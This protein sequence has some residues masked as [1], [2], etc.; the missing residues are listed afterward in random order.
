MAL[1]CSQKCQLEDWVRGHKYDCDR[2][3]ISIL[4]NSIECRKH[5]LRERG[6]ITEDMDLS[7][8]FSDTP[9]QQTQHSA[10]VAEY[11]RSNSQVDPSINGILH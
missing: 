11:L 7:I 5:I 4:L 3:Q 9:S 1:Y 6:V 2:I 8:I 10:D